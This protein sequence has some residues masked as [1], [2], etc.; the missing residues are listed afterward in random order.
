MMNNLSEWWKRGV[1]YQIYPRS[2]QD[3]DGD[4]IGDIAG[5]I[6]RLDYLEWLGVDA[7]WLSPIYASPM[8]DF[9]Y[10][11]ANYRDIE[12]IFGNLDDFDRLVSEAKA[13]NIRVLLDFVPNHSSDQHPWFLESRSSRDN[14]K[15]D[16]YIW[17]DANPDGSP[18]N[19]WLSVFGGS[20][21][22]WDETTGQYYLHSF[23]KEQPDLNW[24]NPEVV[25]EIKDSLAFWLKR[26]VSGFRLDVIHFL[27]KDDQFRDDPVNPGFTE[28]NP[29]EGLI[30]QYSSLQ[31][32]VYDLIHEFR[33]VIDFHGDN[34]LIGEINYSAPIEEIVSFYDGKGLHLPFNFWLILLAWNAGTLR[35]FIHRFDQA[36]P[37][38]GWPNYV[39]GNHDRTRLGSRIGPEYIRL[40]AMLLLS[41]RGTPFIYYGEELGMLDV[42]IPADKVQDPWEINVPGQGRDPVRTPMLWDDKPNAGFTEGTPW[43]PV[44]A[45]YAEH[46]VMAQQQ[47]PRS[48]LHLY[49][50]LLQLRK[51]SD[52]IGLGDY[53][54]LH[55]DNLNTFVFLRSYGQERMIVALNFSGE[56][57]QLN[58]P[59]YEHGQIE[60][61]TLSDRGGAV[62]LNAFALRP[63]E[64]CIIRV[65]A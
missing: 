25:A 52:A 14:P 59:D 35:D 55:T 33:D 12:P 16:W 38:G 60:L 40:A 37:A 6:Q 10:D 57:Q 8:A 28:G 41:L 24:R 45:H 2:F 26:G 53:D 18:P 21:W 29:W 3:G 51:E 7:I 44:T 63:Y 11:V 27:L 15:R 19:N 34:V 64:G 30:H 32:G 1:V 42:P 22:E 47:D 9:G 62:Q 46:S 43:L 56:T 58:L 54:T 4:G 13:R 48:V 20:A 49:R 61:S 36:I 23:L 5:I 17:K 39:L 50:V 31:P 65:G